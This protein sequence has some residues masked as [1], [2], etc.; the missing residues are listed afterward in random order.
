MQTKPNSTPS[1]EMS[2]ANLS[3]LALKDK[4]RSRVGSLTDHPA[5]ADT[6]AR[7]KLGRLPGE[8]KWQSATPTH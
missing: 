6:I 4:R 5:F 2:E 1:V 8:R 7:L 3:T